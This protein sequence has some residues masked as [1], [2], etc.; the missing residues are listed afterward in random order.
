MKKIERLQKLSLSEAEVFLTGLVG[1]DKAK[2]FFEEEQQAI[3]SGEAQVGSFVKYGGIVWAVLDKLDGGVLLLAKD[4]LLEKAFDMGNHNNWDS[5]SLRKTMNAIDGRGRF[6]LKELAGINTDDLLPITRDLLTDDGMTDYGS[7]E[8]KISIY[9]T[10]EYR[11][12][13][14]YIPNA[15][16]WHWT[17]TGDS[18]VYSHFVRYVAS[19]GTLNYSGAYDDSGGVRPLCILKSEISV[20]LCGG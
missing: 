14:K 2:L 19:D 4:C 17:I 10:E 15:G 13:R 1:E 20:E 6:K 11:R 5:S 3:K 9:T 16:K 7:C 8:D 12:Y 18:L